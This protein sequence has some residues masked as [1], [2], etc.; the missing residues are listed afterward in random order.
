[1]LTATGQ[2]NRGFLTPVERKGSVTGARS[3]QGDTSFDAITSNLGEE[4]KE[5][6]SQSASSQ[7]TLWSGGM[8]AMTMVDTP[9]LLSTLHLPSTRTLMDSPCGGANRKISLNSRQR[10]VNLD[11][12][13]MWRDFS[14]RFL[15]HAVKMPKFDE[16]LNVD[17]IVALLPPYE[18]MIPKFINDSIVVNDELPWFTINRPKAAVHLRLVFEPT[19]PADAGQIANTLLQK[20]RTRLQRPDVSPLPIVTSFHSA[21]RWFQARRAGLDPRRAD[22]LQLTPIAEKQASIIGKESI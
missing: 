17:L 6:K 2:L 19:I 8:P 18:R 15:Q 22:G 14:L 9:H 21:N 20:L 10:A 16:T 12:R 5:Q 7:L 11:S 1:M 4:I 13:P 3:D